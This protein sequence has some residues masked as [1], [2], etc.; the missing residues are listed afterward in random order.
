MSHELE[1]VTLERMDIMCFRS[2][3]DT[4]ANAIARLTQTVGEGVTKCTH[5]GVM[6]NH[7]QISEQLWKN[8]LHTFVPDTENRRVVVFRYKREF[9]W[10][11][12]K[13]GVYK[14]PG[15]GVAAD[16][17]W[18]VRGRLYAW[19]RLPAHA[20]TGIAGWFGLKLN[21]KWLL[22]TSRRYRICSSHVGRVYEKASGDKRF[23]G[24]HW[25][26]LTPDDIWDRCVTHPA[27][28][29]RIYDSSPPR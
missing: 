25:S 18:K 9:P 8:M 6:L 11:I 3:D 10:L 27:E 26:D 29:E 12:S 16:Y 24:K 15:E 4:V 2:Y 5:I 17:M 22:R 21:S 19:W 23:F 20:I 28:F 13:S 7:F 14:V 1:G